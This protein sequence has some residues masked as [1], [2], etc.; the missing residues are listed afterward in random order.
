MRAYFVAVLVSVSSFSVPSPGA[1]QVDETKAGAEHDTALIDDVAAE[2]KRAAA[3]PQSP[4]QAMAQALR[5]NPEVLTAEAKVRAMEAELNRTRL[6]VV[7]DV[8]VAYHKWVN[9]KRE[10]DRH[11]GLVKEGR[12]IKVE[13]HQANQALAECETELMY[14]LGIRADAAAG[15]VGSSAGGEAPGTNRS[16]RAL[17]PTSPRTASGPPPAVRPEI[18]RRFREALQMTVQLEFTSQPMSDVLKFLQDRMQNEVAF[19]FKG[20]SEWRP[21]EIPVDL[22]L[23]GDKLTVEAALEALADQTDCCFVFRDYGVLVLSRLDA[24]QYRGA[25]IPSDTPLTPPAIGGGI[26]LGGGL[27]GLGGGIGVPRN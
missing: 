8:T 9:A 1:A 7:R 25:A 19:V 14:L 27:G 22:N 13:F 21:E 12:G 17:D 24:W 3:R 26:D 23:R 4:E 20:A 6:A 5:T 2:Q 16:P 18:P 10:L 11:R 15:D